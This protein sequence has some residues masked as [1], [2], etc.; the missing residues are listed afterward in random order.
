MQ[1]HL[2]KTGGNPTKLEK[3]YL[4][5]I[6]KNLTKL[7]KAYLY[8]IN[9]NTG[10]LV[11]LSCLNFM[12]MLN[13]KYINLQG[14]LDLKSEFSITLGKGRKRNHREVKVTGRTS[15]KAVQN[16]FK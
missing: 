7:E 8:L 12:K 2:R 6:N 1:N 3:V 14:F 10:V 15:Q 13:D 11:K 16:V 5:L 9:K 4:H